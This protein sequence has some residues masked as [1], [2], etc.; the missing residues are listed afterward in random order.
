M[1]VADVDL[2]YERTGHSTR[3][4]A[5]RPIIPVAAA[6]LVYRKSLLADRYAAMLERLE[7]PPA[8]MDPLD[9]SVRA[10]WKPNAL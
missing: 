1:I 10:G 7:Q 8:N 5:A 3:Y 6:S 4:E 2:G 9:W